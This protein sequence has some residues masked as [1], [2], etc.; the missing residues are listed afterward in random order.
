MVFGYRFAK[1]GV[2][3]LII[4]ALLVAA[5][6]IVA[7]AYGGS[8]D[9]AEADSAFVKEEEVVFAHITDTHYYSAAYCGDITAT[10]TGY[11]DFMATSMKMVIESAPYNVAAL[12]SI[13]DEMPDY[14]VVTGDLTLNGEIQGHIEMANLLRQLQERVRR[15]GNPGFQVFVV[16]GNH[17]MYNDEAFSYRSNENTF[18][19]NVTR[20]D[21]VKIYSSLGYPDLTDAEIAEYYASLIADGFEL[22][23]D[24]APYDASMIS[25][26][27]S[28]LP[29]VNST[30]AEGVEAKWLYRENGQEARLESGEIEDYDYGDISAIFTLPEGYNV[31]LVD[32]E[33]SNTVQQ[34]HLGAML[35]DSV[36]EWLDREKAAGTFD[37]NTIVAIQHHNALPH[38]TGEDTLLKDFTMY[39]YEE[40]ADYMADLGVRYV[41]SGHMHSNDAVS[42]VS[43]NGNLLTDIETS[44]VTGYRGA[45]RYAAISRGKVGDKAAENLEMKLEL[46]ESVDFGNLFD[47]GLITDEYVERFGLGEF[48]NSSRVV[49]DPSEYAAN[50]LFLNIIENVVYG[51]YVNVDFISGLGDMVAS[52]LPEEATGIV[53]SLLNSVRPL[54]ATFVNNLIV[55]IEDVVLADYEYG[56]NRAEFKSDERGAKL[57][58]YL[59]ELIQKAAFMPL[60]AAGDTLFDF[61][62]GAYL[63]HVG[64]TDRPYSEATA[65]QKEAFENLKSGESIEKLLAILL[66]ENSG[67]YRIVM[68]LFTPINL[69]QGADPAKVSAFEKLISTLVYEVDFGALDLNSAPFLAKVFSLLS[70]FGLDLGFDLKGMTGK[71]FIDDVLNSYVTDALYTSLGEIAYGIVYAFMIDEEAAM[72]NSVGEYGL[73][74]SDP[75]LA[76]SWVAGEIDNT[77][78]VERGMLPSQLTVTFGSD[79]A[80]TKNFV[81]F[82]DDAITGTQIQYNKGTTFDEKEAVTVSGEFKKYATTTANIDLGIY[83]TL[84]QIEVGRHFVSLTGLES[85]ATY[86]YRVGSA[87]LGYWSDVYTFTTAPAEGTPFEA[88]LMTDIQGSGMNP[89][90]IASMIMDNIESQGIFSD[91]FDFVI[92][93][94]DVVD[95]DRNWVQWEYYLEFMQKYWANTT[96][97]VANGNHDKHFYEGIDTEDIAEV[98]EY[99]W[100]DDSV[101][102]IYNYLLLHFGLD[103]PEQDAR[104]G[105]YYSFD[106]SDVHFTV[107]N[108]N[109]LN[110]TTQ[111]LSA[112]QTEWLKN[113]LET[114]DKK[115]KIVIMHKSLYSAGSHIDDGDVVAL[116]KQLTPIFADNGVCLVLSGHDHTYSESYYIDRNGDAMEVDA[117]ATTELGTVEGGVLYVS[118]GTFGD[119]F[120]NYR[121]SDDI[122]LEFGEKL[123]DPTLSNPTFGKLVYDGEKL[124]YTGYQ[125]DTETQKITPVHS[126]MSDLERAIVIA[127]VVVASVLVLVAV[128]IAVRRAVKVRRKRS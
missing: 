106:Y 75:A 31:I 57:C 99:M 107:L 112:A 86:S 87:E 21:V 56:G 45:V 51:S 89:Y 29:F 54:A 70:S 63:D 15:A 126:G 11:Y 55:H 39:N 78:S 61:V 110:A 33:L 58:G 41:F 13:V 37:G 48:I 114:T 9:S 83:A 12:D 20:A 23:A 34:H 59:D 125:F 72:E 25:G 32:E 24:R 17:D 113:D 121:T 100:L 97:V 27:E 92:N 119:K 60:N 117:D 118:M 108:T 40:T 2:V 7:V 90:E 116:R 79:P 120:Y 81:W 44:S 49:T 52:L 84:M 127:A 98:A 4:A 38:F 30:T 19:N 128:I 85:G 6:G 101:Q 73:Y 74:Q 22:Y 18:V 16:F 65:D 36:S 115:F 14:L 66:D 111:E 68:G 122:P 67:L 3:L 123:H 47:T 96:T 69:E 94:G 53:G 82:T 8:T 80:T 77:P 104:T 109:N 1:K 71:E 42:R 91:G 5:L 43:L 35:F 10:D 103:Y 95:N 88:L 102:D 124:W 93:T 62:M 28:A 46:L 64:G 105:A 26:Y 50:K 76:A